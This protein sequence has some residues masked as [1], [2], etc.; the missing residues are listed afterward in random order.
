MNPQIF[1]N[2]KKITQVDEVIAFMEYLNRELEASDMRN[3]RAF[4]TTYLIITRAVNEKV[5]EGFFKYPDVM[6]K[7]D[8]VF[9]HYYF[10]ALAQFVHQE[11]CPD[12]WR[13]LF[14][15][16]RENNYHQYIFMAL[17]VNA[18]VNND[19]PQSLRGANVGEEFFEDY[20]KVNGIIKDS[21][22]EVVDSL[23]EQN[24][25]IRTLSQKMRDT[26]AL[27]LQSLIQNWRMKAWEDYIAL[28]N[29]QK[30]R[31]DIENSASALAHEL[32]TMKGV[33]DLMKVPKLMRL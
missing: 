8:V 31:E 5:K 2:Y 32:C 11:H 21:L 9:A 20:E 29:N 14:E 16:S 18:H 33:F 7:V 27:F 4:N 23:Q 3:L 24:I 15:Q 25:I 12:A 1:A 26:Y 28:T 6:K 13:L 17:G 10:D 30:K 19:L 22:E